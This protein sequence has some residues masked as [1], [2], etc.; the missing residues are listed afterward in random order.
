M[1]LRLLG[2]ALLACVALSA[3]GGSP[4]DAPPSDALASDA[5]PATGLPATLRVGIIPNIAPEQQRTTYAPFGQALGS[6]LGV[7][8][9]L[10][11]A[12]SYAG[13]VTA[14]AAEIGRAHV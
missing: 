2:T 14:L 11:V 12:P 5:R 10:F 7:Q 9:E 4:T 13:V 8:V 6:A 3:C 1:R